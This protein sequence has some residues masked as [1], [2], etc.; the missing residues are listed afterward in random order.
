MEAPKAMRSTGM[1]GSKSRGRTLKFTI[2]SSL[3][4]GQDVRQQIMDE[5]GRNGFNY[6]STY[7]LKLALEEA[8]VNAIKHGNRLDPSKKVQIEARVDAK[9]AEIT[10][11]DE[12]PGFDKAKVPDPTR[13]ENLERCCGRGILLIESYMNSAEWTHGGRRLKMVKLNEEDAL[14]RNPEKC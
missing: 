7:A 3:S 9:Q 4:E 6:H 1:A 5:V 14:P 8:L 13:D 12:G 10:I 11:E 2:A